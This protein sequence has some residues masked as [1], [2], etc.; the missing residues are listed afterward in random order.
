MAS[1]F[2]SKWPSLIDIQVFTYVHMYNDSCSTQ[3]SF[4]FVKSAFPLE[5]SYYIT[6]PANIGWYNVDVNKFQVF[7]FLFKCPPV[8]L[9]TLVVNIHPWGHMQ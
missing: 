7:C 5:S 2:G 6:W 8:L 3:D 1:I 9:F 4:G